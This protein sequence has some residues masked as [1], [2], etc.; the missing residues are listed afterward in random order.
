MCSLIDA[1]GRQFTLAVHFIQNPT[2]REV[3]DRISSLSAEVAWLPAPKQLPRSCGKPVQTKRYSYLHQNFGGEQPWS[4]FSRQA[5][6]TFRCQPLPF[7]QPYGIRQEMRAAFCHVPFGYARN[8]GSS[9]VSGTM[10]PLQ[11][12]YCAEMAPYTKPAMM[13][14]S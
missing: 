1:E 7:S 2:Y 12:R 10:K 5:A 9:H 3:F 4:L 8:F 6:T 14:T 13:V 11:S